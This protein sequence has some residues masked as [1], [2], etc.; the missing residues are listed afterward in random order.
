MNA[1]NL[2]KEQIKSARVMKLLEMVKKRKKR[3]HAA[4][5]KEKISSEFSPYMLANEVPRIERALFFHNSQAKTARMSIAATRDRYMLL[6][7]IYGILRGESIIKCDLSDLCDILLEDQG[8]HE[9]RILIMRIVTG[10]TNGLKTLYGRVMRNTNEDL[11]PI[12][13][14]ALY[15]FAR[16]KYGGEKIDWT[17][18]KGWFDVKLL[19]DNNISNNKKSI[20]DQTYAKSIKQ[21]TY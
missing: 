5:Y 1:N 2:S 17:S 11:C 20:T 21:V 6:Q 8:I 9:C 10:K 13:A 14:L 15:L 16:F 18:N 7:T 19:V 4:N 3:L 12:G